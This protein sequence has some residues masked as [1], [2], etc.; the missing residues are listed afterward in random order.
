MQP[1]LE[2]EQDDG[3]A[4]VAG[5]PRVQLDEPQADVAQ[6]GQ[7]VGDD[8]ASHGQHGPVVRAPPQPVQ[9]LMI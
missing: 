5:G 2:S 1:H 3:G 6:E 9:P 8:H 4:Q 7:E